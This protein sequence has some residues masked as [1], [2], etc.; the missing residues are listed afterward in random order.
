MGKNSPGGF[1]F[2]AYAVRRAGLKQN[3]RMLEIGCGEGETLRELKAR[4]GVRG[5]GID[6]SA[7]LI[8]SGRARYPDADIREGDADVLEFPPHSFDGVLIECVLSAASMQPEVLREVHCV[9]KNGGK[10]IISDLCAR[11]SAQKQPT[12]ARANVAENGGMAR[13]SF[14]NGSGGGLVDPQKLLNVCEAL[15]FVEILWEDRTKDLD[16]FVIEKIM[17]HGSL[18]RYYASITAAGV[19][20]EAFCKASP[21]AGPLGYFLLILEKSEK[22][23]IH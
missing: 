19:P 11:E 10:L 6:R 23:T 3:D 13:G 7:A 8:E 20:K 18:E 5:I 9:L 2:T 4:F 12:A 17:E 22:P 14:E 16:A 21:K 15:G 1:A